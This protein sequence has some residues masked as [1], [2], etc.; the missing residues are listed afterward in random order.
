MFSMGASAVFACDVGSVRNSN[1]Y[2]KT[3]LKPLRL[4]ITPHETLVIRCLVGGFWSTGGIH[5]RVQKQ[6]PLSPRFKVALH[7]T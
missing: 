1:L 6:S 2:P 5:F 3:G 4:M 7:S